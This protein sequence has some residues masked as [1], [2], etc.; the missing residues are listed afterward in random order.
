MCQDSITGIVIFPITIPEMIISV[1]SNVC[2][3]NRQKNGTQWINKKKL[4]STRTN[5]NLTVLVL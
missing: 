3:V 2:S 4:D 5:C 1:T